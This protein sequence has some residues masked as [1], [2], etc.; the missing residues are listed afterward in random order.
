[1]E[2]EGTLLNDP[3]GSGRE[4]PGSP[5]G[6]VGRSILTL[7]FFGFLLFEIEASYPIGTGDHTILTADTF[8]EILHDDSV[9]TA[10]RCYCRTNGHTG[11]II[12]VHTG[13]RNEF[14]FDARI[15]TAC[16]C[17]H[18]VPV[19]LPSRLLLF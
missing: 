3:M 12:A 1:M 9:F 16:C 19:D 18:F 11:G 4:W 8:S 13:H 14:R 7:I 15:F 2:T 6:V 5:N 10:V 17:D